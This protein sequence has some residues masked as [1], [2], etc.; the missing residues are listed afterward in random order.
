MEENFIDETKLG[1]GLVPDKDD[2]RD[3]RYD[4]VLWAG[5]VMSDAEWQQWYDI[6]KE[7]GIDIPIKDQ[8]S[9]ESCV[10]QGSSYYVWVL[11]AVETGKYTEVSAKSI[12]SQIFLAWGGAQLR[13]AASLIC[14]WGA[15]EESVVPSKRSDGSVDEAFMED[16][17]WLNNSMTQLAKNLEWKSYASM[18]GLGIDY[19]ARAI[20][21]N[22]GCFWGVTGTNNGTW[23]SLE[24]QPPT[25]ATPQS[26]L[27]N[28]CLFFGKFG[29]DSKGKFIA[30]P[31]SWN[32][33]WT[34]TL[35]PD[36]WQKIRENY[37]VENNHWI[38]N[39]WTIVD[40]PNLIKDMTFKKEKGKANI[41]VVDDTTKTKLVVIDMDTLQALNWTNFTEVDSLAWY[42][43]K[44][45]LIFVNREIN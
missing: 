11:N 38:I 17:S 16:K 27:W 34:D 42:A 4:E 21:D 41:Y 7:L 9:S 1:K 25:D 19:F 2:D 30:T 43:T 12:Y 6:E 37:F 32:K 36:G 8:K 40:K 20:K 13:D 35:H 28:H 23:L 10:W 26:S 29:I 31:N 33:L 18:R 15:L 24:P 45:T 44:W 5:T 14:S 22:H 39:P 3:L